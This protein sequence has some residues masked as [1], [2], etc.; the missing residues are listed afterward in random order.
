[1]F[2]KAVAIDPGYARAYAGIADC[3]AFLWVHGDLDISYD[4]MLANSSKAIQLAPNLAEAHA[5]RALA[6]YLTGH[7]EEASSAFERAIELDP[8][9]FEACFFY[10][11]SCREMGHFEKAAA[12]FERAAELS[13][14]DPVSLCILADVHKALGHSKQ[15]EFCRSSSNGSARDCSQRAP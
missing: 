4:Q 11:S 7:A 1:M 8:A 2:A 14:S 13:P 15:S 10:A 9:L 6:L 5:S 3:D 12:L